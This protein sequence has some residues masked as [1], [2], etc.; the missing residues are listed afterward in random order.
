MSNKEFDEP[1]KGLYRHMEKAAV[2]FGREFLTDELVAQGLPRE[3]AE[4]MAS[5][6]SYEYLTERM[7]NRDDTFFDQAVSRDWDDQLRRERL[8]EQAEGT[9]T[10][11]RRARQKLKKHNSK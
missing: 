11:A 7:Q 4:V 8:R 5:L 1:S 3:D 2:K 10:E 9:G 6:A